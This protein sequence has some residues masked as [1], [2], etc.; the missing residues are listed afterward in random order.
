[1]VPSHLDP[2]DRDLAILRHVAEFGIT[3]FAILHRLFFADRKIDAVKSTLRRLCRKK[4]PSALLR[5]ERWNPQCLVYRLTKQGLRATGASGVPLRPMGLQARIRHMA[6]LH[7]FHGPTGRKLRFVSND[8]LRAFLQLAGNRLPQ[9]GFFLEETAGGMS[10]GYLL[11]DHGGD[12]RRITRKA[13]D[14][15]ARFLKA[16]WFNDFLRA[17]RFTVTILTFTAAKKRRLH[18]LLQKRLEGDLAAPLAQ[19]GRTTDVSPFAIEVLPQMLTLVLGR[20][21]PSGDK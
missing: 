16:G 14:H 5:S 13:A 18:K 12:A 1:M 8:Q 21:S 20:T 6:R 9:R 3:Q 11:V 10:L 19:L 4:S 15:L 17:K 7:F 2:T